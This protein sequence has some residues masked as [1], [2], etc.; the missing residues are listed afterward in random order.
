MKAWTSSRN[1]YGEDKY[2]KKLD[3]LAENL[4]SKMK[5]SFKIS[6]N[7][8]NKASKTRRSRGSK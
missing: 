3:S 1:K 5:K 6:K 4:I 2:C 7:G 8:K